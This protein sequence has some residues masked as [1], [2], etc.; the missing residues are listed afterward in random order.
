MRQL[1]ERRLSD[2]NYKKITKS[3]KSNK[4][5]S[6]TKN[7]IIKSS[8]ITQYYEDDIH[9]FEARDVIFEDPN[10]VAVANE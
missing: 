3:T 6:M 10:S 4:L 5:T 8:T 1:L 7:N 2:W 9:P